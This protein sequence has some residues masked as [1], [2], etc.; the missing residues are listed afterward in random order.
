MHPKI[1]MPVLI[2]QVLERRGE[3]VSIYF[4]NLLC[5]CVKNSLQRLPLVANACQASLW[6]NKQEWT[7]QG[8]WP[9]KELC[10]PLWHRSSLWFRLTY[11]CEPLWKLLL[12]SR[13]W[14]GLPAF[15][16]HSLSTELFVWTPA[17]GDPGFSSLYLLKISESPVRLPH[18][19]SEYN[20]KKKLVEAP[21]GHISSLP[22]CSSTTRGS[23]LQGPRAGPV[24]Q[25]VVVFF[26]PLNHILSACFL[27][28]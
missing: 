1:H 16:F 15:A 23:R 26:T 22:V 10:L 8:V 27:Q 3:L 5:L 13:C 9:V 28:N 21:S 19:W 14:A 24:V 7:V 11:C 17:T 6:S 25:A 12:G 18:T 2:K 4:V 20:W